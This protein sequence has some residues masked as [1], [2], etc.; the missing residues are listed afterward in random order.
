MRPKSAHE[1]GGDVGAELILSTLAELAMSVP[2]TFEAKFA[3][4]AKALGFADAVFH[5]ECCVPMHVGSGRQ[6]TAREAE[7][8]LQLIRNEQIT[9]SR[10]ANVWQVAIG[11]DDDGFVAAMMPARSSA[12]R[13]TADDRRGDYEETAVPAE[14][15]PIMSEKAAIARVAALAAA[16]RFSGYR[17]SI[18]F[19]PALGGDTTEHSA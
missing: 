13:R 3:E 11:I 6:L 12:P 4:A 2:E 18:H 19:A 14:A 9:E 5:V 17:P 7:S 10:S 1:L 15:V 16:I 8:L